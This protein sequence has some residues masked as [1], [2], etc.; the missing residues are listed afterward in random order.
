MEDIKFKRWCDFGRGP[1]AEFA[2][3]AHQIGWTLAD[4]TTRYE[5]RDW[6]CF[7]RSTL[8]TRITNSKAYGL[9][10]REEERVLTMWPWPER[11]RQQ[12]GTR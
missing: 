4:G 1:V 12:E 7:D 10:T 3:S 11:D 5:W 8:E 6:V 2:T 9:D